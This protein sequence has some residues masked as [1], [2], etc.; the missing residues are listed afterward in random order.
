M[1]RQPNRSS[2]SCFR[3]VSGAPCWAALRNELRRRRSEAGCQT[4][5]FEVGAACPSG[6]AAFRLSFDER[7]RGGLGDIDPFGAL[8]RFASCI[9]K[10]GGMGSGFVR[11]FA[12]LDKISPQHHA[13]TFCSTGDNNNH[14]AIAQTLKSSSKLNR[15]SRGGLMQNTQAKARHGCCRTGPGA[16][17]SETLSARVAPAPPT[18]PH[19][20]DVRAKN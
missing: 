16:S 20:R 10:L 14:S 1:I 19:W 12:L 8:T 6:S 2:E 4:W 13:K 3:I 18:P 5:R 15:C 11:A 17:L 9:A 7:R